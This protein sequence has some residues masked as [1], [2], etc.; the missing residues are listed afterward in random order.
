MFR[1]FGFNWNPRSPA[2]NAFAQ[3]L[4][5]SIR[6]AAGWRTA[7]SSPELR[8]Y[9]IGDR[10]GVNGIYR[11]PAE[12]GVVLGRLFRRRGRPGAAGDIDISE[13]EG[14]QIL[15]TSGQ[16]LVDD[17][18]GRYIAVF[19]D[20]EGR[21]NLLRD[22]SG[23]LPCYHRSIEGVAVFFSWL[24][25]WIAFARSSPAL[26]VNWEA[27]AALLSLRHLGGQDTALEGISQILPGKLT[28]LG[29]GA[30]P[31]VS[32]WSAVAIARRPTEDVPEVA[33][34]RLRHVVTECAHAWSSCYG[35]FMLRLSGGV[36][37]A[38]LLGSLSAVLRRADVTCLN[39]HSPGSDSDERGYARLAAAKARVPLIERARD[40]GFRLEDILT[41]SRMPTPENYAGRMGTSRIDAEVAGA[42]H[43][44]AMFTGAGGDQL[45]LQLRCTWPAADYLKIHG[46]GRGFV[47]ASLDSARLGR[48]SLLQSMRRALADR[49]RQNDPLDGAGQ[50][51]TLA[52]REA[53]DG[54]R[55][56]DRYLHPDLSLASDLPIGKFHQVHD[57]VNAFGYYDP[58]LGEAAPEL[59][60]PLLSQPLIEL[61]L[62]L[63]TWLLTCGGRGRALARRA[64]ARDIPREIATRQSKGGM[65]EHVAAVLDRNL[66]FAR[67]LLLDG[68]LVRQGLL[69][70]KK[71][72]A[73]LAGRVSA[74]IGYV[75]EIHE[76]IAIEAWARRI[77]DSPRLLVA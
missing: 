15:K 40:A 73:A 4:D 60:N 72:E 49:R 7:L 20:T 42:H 28:A 10:P 3:C 5:E 30:P 64:F 11:L 6:C 58:Y 74:S 16:A 41:V 48:V 31:P 50:F 14:T 55:R 35:A 17:Y 25:D 75:S 63:P 76:C 71:V 21:A 59:V 69:D 2:Q 13:G 56:L 54:V 66:A 8:V 77:A 18:W 26:R 47:R 22:P 19:R 53:L 12:Q 9:V 52:R 29:E 39:Y 57:L 61:C 24:E 1:Y 37:S 34:E 67:S 27:I 68:H 36:D 62:A 23:T 33:A 46:L 32:L 45:F 70:R 38:I 65:E 44:S 51:A 43:A